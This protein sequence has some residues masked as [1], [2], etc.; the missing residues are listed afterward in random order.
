MIEDE[1]ALSESIG[2]LL[3][4][5][6]HSPVVALNGAEALALMSD[7]ATP[8]DLILS[9][10]NLPDMTGYDLLAFAKKHPKLFKV[11]FVFLSA[12]ADEKEVRKG[13][14]LGATDYLTKPLSVKVLMSAIDAQLNHKEA[15]SNMYLD[16]VNRNWMK[17]VGQNF[18]QEY[19]SPI[20]AL[21]N[22]SR[23]LKQGAAT[24]D[25][26]A[27]VDAVETINAAY[28]RIYRNTTNLMMLGLLT[29]SPS[30]EGGGLPRPVDLSK[31]VEGV[32]RNH[33]LLQS[34]VR[35]Q[36][37]QCEQ[38]TLLCGAPELLDII[39]TE[40][41]DNGVRFSKTGTQ[42]VV[43]LKAT[44]FGAEFS[45]ANVASHDVPFTCDDVAAFRKF[46]QDVTMD[47]LGIGLYVCKRLCQG[48]DA[49]LTCETHE[50]SV[51][52][53]VHFPEQL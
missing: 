42:P 28:F 39:V 7:P 14:D 3:E 20:N 15:I 40:L 10:I 6:G 35:E 5:H 45:V 31:M 22:A 16:E 2:T 19:F 26:A 44:P 13:M 33:P 24:V 11:P 43:S 27:V 50:R 41:V 29:S 37:L 34:G 9:D 46:H 1:L 47:G 53:T 18:R 36:M 21:I 30:V 32:V 52:V 48:F 17:A 12:F 4:L 38:V 49:T 25:P 8:I 23:P 51:K